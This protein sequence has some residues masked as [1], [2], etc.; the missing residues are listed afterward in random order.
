MAKIGS[1]ADY[2]G[3]IERYGE[4]F[5]TKYS[6]L[7]GAIEIEGRD[8]DGLDQ[9]DHEALSA[10]SQIIY[11]SLNRNVSTTAYYAHF[12][13][14]KV[15]L[16][17]RADPKCNHLSRRRETYLNK[18]NLSASKI[19][20]YIELQNDEDINNL[21]FLGIFKHLLT[22]TF[23]QRS[24]TIAKHM[25]STRKAFLIEMSKLDYMASQL[26]D[27]VSEICAKWGGLFT[28]RRLSPNEMWAHMRFLATLDPAMLEEAI[29][30]AIP[31]SDLDI[32]VTGGDIF[33][34]QVAGM[35]VLK[36]AGPVT[37]YA[38]I[39]AVRRFSM[40]GGRMRPGLWASDTNAP[41][42]LKGNY[43]LVTRWKPFS[44]FERSMLFFKKNRA[45]ER[46]SL[47]LFQLLRGGENR[48]DLERQAS[49]KRALKQK[50][51][52]LGIAES[53]P[54]RWG[55]GNAFV[56]VFGESPQ[57]IKRTALEANRSCANSYVNLIWET[58]AADKAFQ[59]LQP[60]QGQKSGR[61]IHMTASQFGAAALIYQ[62]SIG[63]PLVFDLR[64]NDGNPE[65]AQYVFKSK[66][67]LPFNFSS[68]VGGRAMLIGVGP[69]RSGKTFTKNTLATHY[70]KYGGLYRAVDIDPGSELVAASFGDRAGI[71]KI[72]N[73]GSHGFNPFISDRGPHDTA[74]VNHIHTILHQMLSAN[75]TPDLRTITPDE[76]I[77][78]DTALAR[79]RALPVER[80][81]L[82]TLIAHMPVSLRLKFSRWIR[83]L[84]TVSGAN[85]GMHAH[86]FD[87]DVDSVG[88]LTQPIGVFNV[89]AL[90]DDPK[91]LTPVLTE[92]LY[93]ITQAFEA[94]DL[95]ATPKLLDLDE[96]HFALSIPSFAEYVIKKVRTWG[97]WF[98]SIHIWTQSP[99]ELSQLPH[100]AALRSAATT[101]MFMA[102]PNM[103]ESVYLEAFP[104]LSAGELAAIH[105]LVPKREAYIIQP[106]LG[107]SKVVVVDV[108]PEQRVLNTSHPAEAARRNALI[109]E[110]GF[111]EGMRLAIEQLGDGAGLDSA[112]ASRHK[113]LVSH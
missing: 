110:F 100:W 6:S 55:L 15:R 33:A 98:G 48:S 75:D 46:A 5:L 108:E 22:A 56:C 10:I 96:G 7:I 65:E 95:R 84:D 31:E 58:V 93:R 11:G 8:P 82:S 2:F 38:R 99:E 50:I 14:V 102:D 71:F 86:L 91:E 4:Y 113:L 16:R 60:G 106:E 13:G 85:A 72:S 47:N 80:R 74:F 83:P 88:P 41:V 21:R 12:E 66:D 9:E 87:E 78:I 67:D 44:E 23:D 97:K 69:I 27:I 35:D 81:K 101:F 79:T 90:R 24:R 94:P 17:P 92:I 59:T 109:E 104:F 51:E 30:E 42:R 70:Q 29:A 40:A 26:D 45:L 43:L 36:L 20:H 61:D 25:L 1:V 32:Y 107:I 73:E 57:E 64:S 62:S 63:Q 111:E 52:D 76:Q 37:R 105:N 89:Q 19:V 54:D 77:G 3:I 68:F 18:G 53:L 103:D 34:N 112:R 49:M 39:A 28:A